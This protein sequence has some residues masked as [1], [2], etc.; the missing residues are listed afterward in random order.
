M[1]TF[2]KE[3]LQAIN[4]NQVYR[5][6]VKKI[7]KKAFNEKKQQMV[8]EFSEHPVTKELSDEESS[9]ISSTLGGYGNLFGFIGFNASYDPITP[10][11]ERLINSVELESV[12]FD[13]ENDSITIKYTVPELDDFNDVANYQG[14]R[15]GGNWIKGIE[16][17]IAGYQR[18]RTTLGE[19]KAGRSGVG[20]QMSAKVKPF[21]GAPN[22]FQNKK[23]MSSIINNFKTSLKNI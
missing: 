2:E 4:S 10:V 5:S 23:Y 3:V 7:V 20:I 13:R 9:N 12:N 11:M 6:E 14:W 18:F 1:K 21:A 16:R 19:R 17:G 22:R 8:V 15:E